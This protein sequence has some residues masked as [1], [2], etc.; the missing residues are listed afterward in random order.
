MPRTAHSWLSLLAFCGCTPPKSVTVGDAPDLPDPPTEETD[1]YPTEPT[2]PTSETGLPTDTGG[3]TTTTPV[4]TTTLPPVDCATLGT[5]P[6][7]I[8]ELGAPRGYHGLAFSDDGKII[9][10]DESSLIAVT[11]DDV[12]AVLAPGIGVVQQ[13]TWID[14]GD[15]LITADDSNTLVRFDPETG[16]SDV[17]TSDNNT[18]G[19]LW[20]PDGKIWI[21]NNDKIEKV[22]PLTGETELFFNQG[23][24][25][26]HSMGFNVGFTRLYIGTVYD[27]GD[28]Y[29]IDLDADA[30]RVG[31]PYIFAEGVGSWQDCIAVDSCDNVYVCDFTN[32]RLY[33]ISPDGSQVGTFIQ[34]GFNEYGHGATFGNGV[35]GWR[36]DALYLPQP[37]DGNTVVE[38]VLGIGAANAL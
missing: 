33:R 2:P 22:D 32:S 10:S 19:V 28:V 7:S 18:Y 20:G 21:A 5:E 27:G 38:V 17:I 34:W 29:A 9:G 25:S 1:S 23:G 24:V 30:N 31:D 4:V 26:P 12:F 37:Y 36:K 3:T 8:T 35:G 6:V 11:Y 13:I 15:L 16:G 14:E